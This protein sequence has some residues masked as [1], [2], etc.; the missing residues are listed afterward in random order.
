MKRSNKF[1]ISDD[2]GLSCMISPKQWQ[3]SLLPLSIWM[4]K[5]IQKLN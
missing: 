5:K 1:L 2:V 3:F 4:I